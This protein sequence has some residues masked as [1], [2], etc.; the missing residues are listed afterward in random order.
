MESKMTDQTL[1]GTS[2]P[3]REAGG[4]LPPSGLE[5]KVETPNPS[6]ERPAIYVACLAAYNNGILHGR[7]IWA[8]DADEM[9]TATRTMLEK[10][11]E[12]H[13][14]E[15]A[16]HDYAGFEGCRISEYQSFKTVAEIAVF[17]QEH[18]ALGATVLEHFGGNLEDARAAL[19]EHYSGEHESL[20][21]YAQSFTVDRGGEIPPSLRNYID[22]NSMAQ[23]MI[24]NGDIYAI[25]MGFQ[26]H[27][28]FLSR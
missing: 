12:P 18:D 26:S 23:D 25:E 7:W 20:A 16:I 2:A 8:D 11:P 24:L 9:R 6:G 17:I 19:T 13:A 10:S 5:K 22:W 27:H 3:S 21:D 14:E 1:N 28:I 4:V 15:W